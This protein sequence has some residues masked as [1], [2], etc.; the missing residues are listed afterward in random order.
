LDL[1]ENGL[2]KGTT[3][4][5]EYCS[6]LKIQKLNLRMNG[7]GVKGARMISVHLKKFTELVNLDISANAIETDGANAILEA[8]SH[9]EMVKIHLFR[10]EIGDEGATLISKHLKKFKSL[11][12][13]N[14]S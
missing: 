7:L 8:I 12:M 13:F 9:C 2:G 1:G 3:A 11:N 4:I 6:Q 5:V 10:N 14:I